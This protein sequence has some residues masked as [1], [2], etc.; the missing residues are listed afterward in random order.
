MFAQVVNPLL[1]SIVHEFLHDTLRNPSN[2]D[3]TARKAPFVKPAANIVEQTENFV[4]TLA[5]PGLQ[6]EDVHLNLE[7]DVLTI[8]AEK[9]NVPAENAKYNLKEFDFA[10]FKRNF[11]VPENV[12]VD[13]IQANYT[14]GILVVTLPKVEPV[15]VKRAIKVA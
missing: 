2:D 12:D 1:N 14:N 7:K 11:I 9:E 8:V 15:P 10:R 3:A 6:K 5:V 13:N 4:I